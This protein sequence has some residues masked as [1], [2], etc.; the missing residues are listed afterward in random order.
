MAKMRGQEDSKESTCTTAPAGLVLASRSEYTWQ[1]LLGRF[2][3]IRTHRAGGVHAVNNGNAKCET[4][5]PEFEIGNRK[6][7]IHLSESEKSN[8]ESVELELAAA[9]LGPVVFVLGGER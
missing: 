4:R 1:P 2:R 5:E 6:S 3:K 9:G 7:K 8:R